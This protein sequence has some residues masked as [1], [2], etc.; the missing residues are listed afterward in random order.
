MKKIILI[1]LCL[2]GCNHGYTQQ[3]L[4]CANVCSE[5]EHTCRPTNVGTFEYGLCYDYCANLTSQPEVDNF[6]SCSECY[7]AIQCNA[8]LYNSICYPDCE[9]T[10]L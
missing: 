4:Q 2:I 3:Q 8:E 9:T 1:A 7:M 5:L 6:Q 10:P